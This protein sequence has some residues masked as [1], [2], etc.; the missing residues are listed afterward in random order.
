LPSI[1]DT[2]YPRFKSNLTREELEDVY[3]PQQAH[4]VDW[5]ETRSKGMVQKL[6]LLVLLKT[7]Q[8]QG[9]FAIVSKIPNGIIQHI[10]NHAHILLPSDKEW[11]MYSQSRTYKR[12]CQFVREY[13]QINLFNQ[14]ARKI[15]LGYDADG[16]PCER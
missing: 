10:A 9:F 16:I 14:E 13:L 12:H 15:M 3:T 8:K 4:E 2:T 1:Q 7:V 6:G 5:A 11:S